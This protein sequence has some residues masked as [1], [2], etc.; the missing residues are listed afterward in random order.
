MPKRVARA[1]HDRQKL[2][3]YARHRRPTGQRRFS[4]RED[5]LI[6]AHAGRDVDLAKKLS[7][8]LQSIHV[9]RARLKAKHPQHN[10]GQS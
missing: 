8:S 10:E 7:R 5:D 2:R 3:Y 1:T 6:M 4:Q 9:R